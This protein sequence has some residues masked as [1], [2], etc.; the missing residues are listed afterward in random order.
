MSISIFLGMIKI[1]CLFED[2]NN[3]NHDNLPRSLT[4]LLI[5]FLEIKWCNKNDSYAVE[6]CK[7]LPNW[8][9]QLPL[10]RIF[11]NWRTNEDWGSQFLLI[12]SIP[13]IPKSTLLEAATSNYPWII[14]YMIKYMS[15]IFNCFNCM[16]SLN[17]LRFFFFCNSHFLILVTK[18]K[19]LSS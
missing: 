14:C 7:K 2:F 15:L 6:F 1:M 19:G 12:F 18:I 4:K 5:L 11:M 3:F 9:R 16:L 13:R 17:F 8:C 10:G